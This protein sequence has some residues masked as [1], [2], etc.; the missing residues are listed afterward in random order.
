M[1]WTARRRRRCRCRC[2]RPRRGVAPRGAISPHHEGLFRVRPVPLTAGRRPAARRPIPFPPKSIF[3]Y[4]KVGTCRL[5]PREARAIESK[6]G[7]GEHFCYEKTEPPGRI[8]LQTP[9]GARPKERDDP[10]PEMRDRVPRR[11][12]NSNH[13]YKYLANPPSILLKR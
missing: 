7:K 5:S 11:P 2:R 10:A 3:K 13:P 12:A 9:D 4:A 1:A 6:I 8:G